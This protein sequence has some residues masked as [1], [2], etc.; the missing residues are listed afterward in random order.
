MGLQT[1]DQSVGIPTVAKN[2]SLLYFLAFLCTYYARSFISLLA[3]WHPG[4]LCILGD[5]FVSILQNNLNRGCPSP[6]TSAAAHR[7]SLIY[8]QYSFESWEF[9]CVDNRVMGFGWNSNESL[10]SRS[11]CA[12]RVTSLFLRTQARSKRRRQRTQTWYESSD[13][14]RNEQHF[15]VDARHC[16][17]VAKRSLWRQ[18]ARK[19]LSEAVAALVS[20]E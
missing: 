8:S 5:G 12:R 15:S 3:S 14:D 2:Y 16:W 18:R 1:P 6:A 13:V 20:I 19:N 7:V 17:P 9:D 4:Y 11:I 10:S